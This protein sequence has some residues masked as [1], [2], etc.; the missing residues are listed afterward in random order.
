MLTFLP[1]CPGASFGYSRNQLQMLCESYWRVFGYQ[2]KPNKY[3]GSQRHSLPFTLRLVQAS[4]LFP[5]YHCDVL[6]CSHIDNL[7]FPDGIK[8]EDAVYVL[9]Y[10]VIMLNTD[11]H[12]PQIRV[13]LLS[14]A[15]WKAHMSSR[16]G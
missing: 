4:P 14:P 1:C 2:E 5:S 6:F 9:A 13:Y 16:N 10:S 11:Q 3:L 7:V 15:C 12:N 8:N